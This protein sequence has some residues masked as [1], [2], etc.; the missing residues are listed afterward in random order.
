MTGVS[1]F[2]ILRGAP[3]DIAEAISKLGSQDSCPSIVAKNV[4]TRGL[5]GVSALK[6]Q[7]GGKERKKKKISF[8]AQI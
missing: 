5:E 4:R 8:R 3:T 7:K 6:G 1:K 2:Q